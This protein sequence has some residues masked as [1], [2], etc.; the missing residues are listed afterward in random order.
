MKHGKQYKG[1]GAIKKK[2]SG[3]LRK[4]AAKASKNAGKQ[5]RKAAE[6]KTDLGFA[7]H[8]KRSKA[9]SNRARNRRNLARKLSS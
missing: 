5:S 3:A 1:G 4:A 2:L 7:F 6:A 9:A 8:S